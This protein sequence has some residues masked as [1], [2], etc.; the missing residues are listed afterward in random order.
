MVLWEEERQARY[1]YTCKVQLQLVRLW[2]W[3]MNFWWGFLDCY[4]NFIIGRNF[5]K[6]KNDL[7]FYMMPQIFMRHLFY[8]IF[9]CFSAVSFSC[10]QTI[11][12]FIILWSTLQLRYIK[13]ITIF[14][15]LHSFTSCCVLKFKVYAHT[16][17][18]THTCILDGQKCEAV[19][20]KHEQII[21]WFQLSP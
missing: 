4:K 3:L 13:I 16:H 7:G 18:H 2:V 8:F 6:K 5:F 12:A 11:Q 9:N 1:W 20:I 10:L 17:T 21:L 19:F 15:H 14:P